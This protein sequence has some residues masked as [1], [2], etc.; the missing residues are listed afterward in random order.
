MVEV[1]KVISIPDILLILGDRYEIFAAATAAMLSRIP[2]AHL[3]GGEITEGAY[4]DMIRHSLTKMSHL[5]FVTH[6]MYK[7]RVI[8]LGEDPKKVFNVGGF[9]VDNI[10][11]LKLAA[12]SS[13]V[14]TNTNDVL[15]A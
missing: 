12:T 4:D 15:K 11:N 2:I 14:P 1:T 5:H 10:K 6:E 7:K 13:Y 8:Q 3:H 9:G